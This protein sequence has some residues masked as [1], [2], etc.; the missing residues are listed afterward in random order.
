[1]IHKEIRKKVIAEAKKIK[2]I[3]NPSAIYRKTGISPI[4]VMDV[5]RE[6]EKKGKVREL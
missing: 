3:I 4:A 2:G 5:L 6:L 1:M